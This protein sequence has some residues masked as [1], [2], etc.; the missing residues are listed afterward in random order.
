MTSNVYRGVGDQ[1]SARVGQEIAFKQFTSTSTSKKVAIGFLLESGKPLSQCTL[2]YIESA[3]GIP[4]YDFWGYGEAEVLLAP[5]DA[6]RVESVTQDNKTGITV[7]RLR[8]NGT[9][10]F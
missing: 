1:F 2:F 7:I 8:S 4:M 6:F 3:R 9:S 10:L 5:N